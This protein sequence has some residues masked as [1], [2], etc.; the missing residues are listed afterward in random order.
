MLYFYL[1]EGDKLKIGEKIRQ[2]RKKTNL[3]QKEL[4]EKL[5][6]SQAMIGQYENGKRQPKLETLGRIA[7]ALGVDVWELYEDYEL[8]END[9]EFTH[10]WEDLLVMN[11][12]RFI[13]YTKNTG[14]C[15][16]L[17]AI[18]DDRFRYFL[19]SDQC[20]RLP[21]MAMEQIKTLIKAMSD[22]LFSKD[23]E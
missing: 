3:S 14:E 1:K 20:E 11:D 7:A 17:F 10:A 9:K 18:D 15:G 21:D 13:N 5:G 16:K 6:V 22:E 23:I 8:P 12:I 2:E 19:T 4:G